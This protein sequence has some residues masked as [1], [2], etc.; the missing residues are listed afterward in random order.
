LRKNILLKSKREKEKRREIRKWGGGLPK[1]KN[2]PNL[3]LPGTDPNPRQQSGPFKNV[4]QKNPPRRNSDQKQRRFG[5]DGPSYRWG[6]ETW[7]MKRT[8]NQVERQKR[9]RTTES[10]RPEGKEN[11]HKTKESPRSSEKKEKF[12]YCW[13][14]T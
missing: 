13:K 9:G 3:R 4:Y 7:S 11:F 1:E 2:G 14:K 10:L 6:G 5:G 8:A 12:T